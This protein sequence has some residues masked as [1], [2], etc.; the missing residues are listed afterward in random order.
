MIWA[1]K[2]LCLLLC[3]STL[4]VLS[5]HTTMPQNITQNLLIQKLTNIE[6]R[7]ESC[8]TLRE[9]PNGVGTHEVNMSLS[10]DQTTKYLFGESYF[11]HREYHFRAATENVLLKNSGSLVWLRTSANW[12][13]GLPSSPQPMPFSWMWQGVICSTLEQ[14]VEQEKDIPCSF[15]ESAGKVSWVQEIWSNS[16]KHI[17]LFGPKI[18]NWK[19]LK[20]VWGTLYFHYP[21]DAQAKWHDFTGV[22][23]RI[24]LEREWARKWTPPNHYETSLNFFPCNSQH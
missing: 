4:A 17:V 22:I 21:I 8:S 7:K 12:E 16:E 1:H 10:K 3:C 15:C 9:S 18:S 13:E 5:W 2:S 24:I 20:P 19:R 6:V 11:P 23:W 14:H